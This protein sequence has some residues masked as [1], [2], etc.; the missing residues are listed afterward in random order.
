MRAADP[1]AELLVLALDT[2]TPVLAAALVRGETVLGSLQSP[3]ERNHSAHVVPAMQQLIRESG[4]DP[5]QLA[6]IAVGQGPGSY[7]GVRIAASVAKTLA[8]AWNRPLVGVSSL[9]ALAAGAWR[10]FRDGRAGKPHPAAVTG[11]T[12]PGEAASAAL[13]GYAVPLLDAAGDR[14]TPR[15]TPLRDRS[16]AGL[17]RMGFC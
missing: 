3:A 12:V 10:A 2:S 17:G 14:C 13:V 11:H 15:C 1:S 5:S 8:W 7:T 16:G 9:E 6:G 4:I